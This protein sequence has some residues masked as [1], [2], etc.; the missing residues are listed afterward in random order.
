M[1][2]RR[3]IVLLSKQN[4]KDFSGVLLEFKE[5][6]DWGDMKWDIIKTYI[7]NST[8]LILGILI[9]TTFPSYPHHTF[10]LVY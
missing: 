4:Q 10:L 3:N 2:R 9:L 5:S 6:E 8:V 7:A 1:H